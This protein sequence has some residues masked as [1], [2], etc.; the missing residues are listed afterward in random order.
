[1][2]TQIMALVIGLEVRDEEIRECLEIVNKERGVRLWIGVIENIIV[3]LLT[4]I[5]G[6]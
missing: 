3:C 2:K 1:M 5:L 4:I 6:I